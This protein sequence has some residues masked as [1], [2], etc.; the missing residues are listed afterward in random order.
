MI[1]A[2]LEQLIYDC[3][4]SDILLKIKIDKHGLQG[5]DISDY[6]QIQSILCDEFIEQG[7]NKDYEPNS[8]GILVEDAIDYISRLYIHKDLQ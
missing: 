8:Y 1:K 7:I 2:Q 5:L 3:I 4:N 6:H